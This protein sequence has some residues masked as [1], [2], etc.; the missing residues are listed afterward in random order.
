MIVVLWEE[1]CS[2]VLGAQQLSW[3]CF[4]WIVK[5]K[6]ELNINTDEPE[7]NHDHISFHREY[8]YWTGEQV[9][10]VGSLHFVN[11]LRHGLTWESP[12]YYSDTD[13]QSLMLCVADP[14]WW[15][16][17][18]CIKKFKLRRVKLF[19]GYQQVPYSELWCNWSTNSTRTTNFLPYIYCNL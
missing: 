16:V 9:R 15:P 11:D 6:A 14:Y 8:A 19:S 5:A 4:G 10:N 2:F 1:D 18:L 12:I 3:L 17:S 7:R 13:R